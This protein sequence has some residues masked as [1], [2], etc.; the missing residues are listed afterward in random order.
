MKNLKK[1]AALLL[2]VMLVA[3]SG[4]AAYADEPPEPVAKIED[5]EYPTL[6]AAVA[7]AKD[8]AIITLSAHMPNMSNSKI[9]ATPDAARPYDFSKCDFSE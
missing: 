8:G 1:A 4:L 7:A 3:M 2:V 6:D 9:K 5:N